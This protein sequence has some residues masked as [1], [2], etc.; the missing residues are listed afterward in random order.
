MSAYDLLLILTNLLLWAFVIYRL[1]S[2]RKIR[3]QLD[4]GDSRYSLLIFALIG[5]LVFVRGPGWKNLL[6]FISFL[7]AGLFFGAIPGGYNEEAIFIHGR[8][9]PL[10]KVTYCQLE[11]EAERYRFTFEIKNK[12]HFLFGPKS[13]KEA[14]EQLVEYCDRE[15]KK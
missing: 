12:G 2:G 13:A 1:I 11:E 10:W 7:L 14:L 3:V 4:C 9:F 15:D 6:T 5:A 8:R